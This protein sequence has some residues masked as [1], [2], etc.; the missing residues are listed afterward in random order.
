MEMFNSQAKKDLETIF[1]SLLNITPKTSKLQNYSS[2]GNM[3]KSI[4][5]IV[6][7]LSDNEEDI[8]QKI[9][10]DIYSNIFTKYE[11]EMKEIENKEGNNNLYDSISFLDGIYRKF[12]Y[13]VSYI[14]IKSKNKKNV[15]PHLLAQLELEINNNQVLDKNHFTQIILNA[16]SYGI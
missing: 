4:I 9:I 6:T 12:L 14:Y 3:L 15:Y 8:T 1:C 10:N 7:M 16:I 5:D 2:D 11:K 13:F